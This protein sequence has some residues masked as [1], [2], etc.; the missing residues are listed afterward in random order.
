MTVKELYDKC[1]N[2]ADNSWVNLFRGNENV[3]CMYMKDLLKRYGESKVEWFEFRK[4]NSY[5]MEVRL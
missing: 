3:D 1:T 5:D 2:I 4:N